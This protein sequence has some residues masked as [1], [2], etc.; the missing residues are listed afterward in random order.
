MV[1]RCLSLWSYAARANDPTLPELMVH[2]LQ[3][4]FLV[5]PQ[6]FGTKHKASYPLGSKVIQ[7]QPSSEV[8]SLDFFKKLQ[9]L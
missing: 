1:L 7:S 2:A 9:V 8:K 3:K 6:S 4:I 5:S